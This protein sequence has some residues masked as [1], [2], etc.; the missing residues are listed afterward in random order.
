MVRKK[1]GFLKKTGCILISVSIVLMG[2]TFFGSSISEA[3]LDADF[4]IE[5]PTVPTEDTGG[6][7]DNTA[8]TTE[9]GQGTETVQG[10]EEQPTETQQTNATEGSQSENTVTD[11][12]GVS[13]TTN[14]TGTE[15]AGNTATDSTN[16]ENTNNTQATTNNSA[17]TTTPAVSENTTE[18]T[19]GGED[20]VNTD[21]L[22]TTSLSM[23]T[24]SLFGASSDMLTASLATASTDS[25]DNTYSDSEATIE[26]STLVYVPAGIGSSYTV[27]DG[28]TTIATNAFSDSNVVY[29]T[30]TDASDISS[31]GS[32]DDWPSDGTKVYCPN[33]SADE[34]TYVVSYFNSLI[35]A[36]R[37]IEIIF[38]EEE[39]K[40]TYTITVYDSLYDTDGTTLIETVVDKNNLSGDYE[41]G[42]TITAG[43]IDGYTL[44]GN[45]TAT[46]TG[47]DV[48]FT[49]KKN[50][51]TT[52]YSVTVYKAL[53]DTDG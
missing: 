8:G 46:V 45:K 39:E 26:G 9:A 47:E 5:E 53:Y 12:T 38:D 51:T 35:T 40:N 42:A 6:A 27:P 52:K 7:G 2:S 19:A 22:A 18:E 32:Q 31:I 21:E 37:N 23:S 15:T 16:P 11:E 33:D 43:S 20:T 41:E 50:S 30:F 49:Y 14:A 36:D 13:N 25:E 3:D 24:F 4:Q 48:V 17:T 28:I 10:T 29:L 34:A 1:K 44:F